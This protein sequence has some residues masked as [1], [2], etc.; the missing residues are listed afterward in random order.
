MPLLSVF[1]DLRTIVLFLVM[2]TVIIAVHELGHYLTARL[3]GMRVLEFAFG[4][5]PRASSAA[6]ARR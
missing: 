3:L 1:S 5:P 2:F 6:S 4:F